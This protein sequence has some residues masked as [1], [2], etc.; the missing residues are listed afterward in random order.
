MDRPLTSARPEKGQ[1]IIKKLDNPT[2]IFLAAGKELRHDD[3]PKL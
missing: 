3:L 2:F 1:A